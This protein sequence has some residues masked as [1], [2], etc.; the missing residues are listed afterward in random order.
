[1]APSLPM[2]RSVLPSLFL[3]P[4]IPPSLPFSSLPLSLSPPFLPSSLL[5]PSLPL[6]S[7]PYSLPPS[8]TIQTGS[9]KTFTI[10]GGVE[11]Y[12]D[13]GLIPRSLSYL[14]Q[15]Y[16]KVGSPLLVFIPDHIPSP[17]SPGTIFSTQ[18][19]YLEI[20]NECGYDLLDPRH[21]AARLEDLP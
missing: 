10:T 12:S 8:L 4:S 3:S 20:Y 17:Q 7:L 11:R 19:S 9:G 16:E 15:Q 14:Y 5:P 21:E 18:I 6:S 2:V 13:R 1:M